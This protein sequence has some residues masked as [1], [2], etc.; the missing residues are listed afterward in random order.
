MDYRELVNLGLSEKEAR[1]YLAALELGK[2]PVQKIAQK[3]GVNRA[4]TYVIIEG[5]MKKGLMS[6]Y[7]EGK[8]QFYF[9]EAPEKLKILFKDQ[10]LGLK[11]K[12]EYLEKLLPELKA[13]NIEKEGRPTVRYFEGK[14]GLRAM[15]EEFFIVKHIEP[16]R[17]IY[18]YD[19]LSD[20]FSKEEKVKL[21]DKR[22][23][24]KI[25]VRSII[26][27]ELNRSDPDSE[28]TR[29]EVVSFKE[30]PITSD[31]AFF[32]D[33]VRIA[34]QKGNLVGLIIENKEITNTF[35]TLF[36]LAWQGKKFLEQKKKKGSKK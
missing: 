34:T 28:A 31:I 2:C 15:A 35:K 33:R 10:E 12:E 32:G 19:L 21:R 20:V 8:K 22:M 9:A 6:S 4:T 27:D 18:S 29:K 25:K 3:A 26:N 1:V 17:M 7:T 13:L 24:Q 23:A 16:A 14:E 11:R 30:F 5:L 36:D